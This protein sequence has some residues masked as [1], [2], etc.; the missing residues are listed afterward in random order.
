MRRGAGTVGGCRRQDAGSRLTGRTGP[1]RSSWSASLPF[2]LLAILVAAQLALAGQALW[3]A[4]VAARAGAR[5]ALVGGRRGGGGAAGAAAVAARRGGGDDRGTVSVEVPVPA[6]APGAAAAD[7]RREDQRWARA[8]G[9]ERGQATV[10]LVAALPALL[11]AGCIALQLLAA[12]YALTL[13]DGAAEAGALALASGRPAA[14]AA[15][16]A[17]PGWADGRRRGERSAA[18]GSRCAC[19]RRRRSAALAERLAVT[20]VARRRGRD[21]DEAPMR[22]AGWR[23]VVSRVGDAEGSR[24]AAAA[25]A[26]AGVRPGPGRPAA[27]SSPTAARRGRAGRHRGA[28][29]LEERLA[30]HLPEAGVAVPRAR[31]ATWRCRRRAREGLDRVPAALAAR[32][33]LDRGRAPAAAPAA[34]GARGR[35]IEPT[36][37]AA[38]RRP[39]PRPRADRA[40]GPRADLP[41]GRRA[42][43][44]SSAR[45][46]G[47]PRGAALFG[48]APAEAPGGLPAADP[49][50]RGRLRARRLARESGQALPL[51]L[52]GCFVLIA[53]GAGAGRDRRGGDRQGPGPAGRRPGR[54]LGGPLDARRPAAPALAADPAER[55]AESRPPGEGRLPA[56]GRARAAFAAAARTRSARLGCGSPSRT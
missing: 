20:G 25:L 42:S 36:A 40:R 2:L 51:A 19:G 26:C 55:P 39:R 52:G 43:R 49:A 22:S 27:S 44:S 35:R 23:T 15:R 17:L 24:A 48:V 6:P 16:D 56:G 18:A 7:G 29:R 1:P 53:G 46:P 38:A 34:G 45:S 21:E 3:S 31:S 32:P 33:R 4:G 11:L 10:E 37:V 12:G 8:M 30:A 14:E 28:R 50:R 13:A 54:D 41:P 9:S 47:S 5:A